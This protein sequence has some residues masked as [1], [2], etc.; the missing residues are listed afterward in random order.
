MW[1]CTGVDLKGAAAPIV[2]IGQILIN[3]QGEIVGVHHKHVLWDYEYTLFEPGNEPYQVFDTEL[4]RLGM[5]VCAD[6][7]VPECPR[8]LGLM[9]AQ[10][11]LNSL[12]SRGPDEMRIHIPLRS[13][14]N[15]V[16]HVA[17]NTVGNPKTEGLL[18]PWTG[19]SSIIDPKGNKLVTAS[20]ELDELV[21]A[22]IRPAEADA[23]VASWAADLFACRR[24]E[25]YEVMTRPVHGERAAPVQA[26][27]GPAPD[28]LPFEGPDVV[29]VAMMQLSFVH[30]RQCTEWMTRRQ[31]SYAKRRGAVLG[32]L[33]ELWCFRRGEVKTDAKEAAVYSAQVLEQMLVAAAE[34][35]I[36]VCFSLVEASQERLYHTAYLVG[37]DGVAG[38]YRK[39]HLTDVERRWATPGDSLCPVL[40]LPALGRVAMMIGSE[41]WIPEVGR[42]L[43]LEGVE[44]VLHPTEW[45]RAECELAATERAGESRFHLVSVNRLD[46]PGRL[47][48]QTTKAGEYIRGEPIPLMRYCE[49]VWARYGVEEQI[50]VQ[51][52]RREPHCKMMGEILDVVEKRYP[53]LCHLITS[54]K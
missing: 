5:L 34:D 44:L 54:P 19:G 27:Y 6:G 46:S 15:H 30:T 21:V 28:T 16:W 52:A 9:G 40:S 10:V 24:P 32:V 33:P 3:P 11:F 42:C 12:N 43:G 36:Y 26:M 7:I 47:G 31:V 37:P 49:G 51:L 23:K 35:K 50:H 53:E 39:S 1:T 22:E 4:G 13:I 48:S 14:E 18:W 17:S 2:Y 38:K 20:E 29:N 41:L 25:L 8:V 45:D